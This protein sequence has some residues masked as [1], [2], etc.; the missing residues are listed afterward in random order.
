[1]FDVVSE[2][3]TIQYTKYLLY[4]TL[5]HNYLLYDDKRKNKNLLLLITKEKTLL[6]S[7]IF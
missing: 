3:N 6:D 1:M 5:S 2:N 4:W 7:E